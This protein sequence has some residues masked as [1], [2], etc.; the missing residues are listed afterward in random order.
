MLGTGSIGEF[1]GWGLGKLITV[2]KEA[3][4]D[5]EKPQHHDHRLRRVQR[6]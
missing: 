5:E 1:V 2:E 3:V 4:D 6:I